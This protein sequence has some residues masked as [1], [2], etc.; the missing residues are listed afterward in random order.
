MTAALVF[1]LLFALAGCAD[2]K[3]GATGSIGTEQSSDANIPVPM[4]DAVTP[5]VGEE[6]MAMLP[7]SP[8]LKKVYS[9]RANEWFLA[10][11]LTDFSQAIEVDRVSYI[12]NDLNVY[13]VYRVN[14]NGRPEQ[15]GEV[16]YSMDY[17]PPHGL[18]G[19][20]YEMIED[21]IGERAYDD[22]IIAQS[23][24][25]GTVFVWVR[26]SEGDVIITYPTR[27]EAVGLENGGEYTLDELRRAIAAAVG[28]A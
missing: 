4:R 3:K 28:N 20:T 1:A 8:E 11:G 25:L 13:T 10:E 22:Y 19:L 6:L 27:P 17:V 21:D 23:N 15:T 5:D 14:A 9:V 16:T 24:A 2:K 18:F 26:S 7:D 12:L